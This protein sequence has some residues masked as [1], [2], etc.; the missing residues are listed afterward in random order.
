MITKQNAD[1]KVLYSRTHYWF[2]LSHGGSVA[3]TEGVLNGLRKRAEIEILS[4]DQIYGVDDIPITIVPPIGRSWYGEL[5]YNFRFRKI[6]KRRLSQSRPDFIYH[7]YN[8][9]SFST[10]SVCRKLKIPLILEFNSSHLWKVKY[11]NGG[12][13]SLKAWVSTF[14]V[15]RIEPFNL[16]CASMLVVVAEPLKKSLVE[17]GVCPDRILVNPNGVS[18]ERFKPAD[19]KACASIRSQLNIPNDCIVVGFA[20]TFGPWHGIPELT[21]AVLRIAED[22]ELYRKVAFVFFGNAS[23]LQQEMKKKT[24]H[25]DRVLFPGAI[26]YEEIGRHLSICDIL[27]SPHGKPIDDG[28]FFGSPTKMFEYMCLGKAIVASNLGQIGEIL[29]DRQTA[30]LCPPGDVAELVKGIRYFIDHPEERERMGKNARAEAL[31]NHTWDHNIDRMLEAF[32]KIQ[33]NGSV[34]G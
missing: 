33:Q 3:H 11:W 26:R 5:L 14:F 17:V 8:G 31:A 15:K 20:G 16:N 22:R 28:E 10:A 18:I 9:F 12:S 19:Q 2:A 30:Y 29:K 24:Q 32:Q 21:E 4:N 6:L 7:R 1:M 25:L 23:D 13:R 34:D 27:L